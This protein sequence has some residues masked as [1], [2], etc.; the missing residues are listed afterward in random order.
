MSRKRRQR[1]AKTKPTQD[2][3]SRINKVISSDE[4]PKEEKA[5]PEKKQYLYTEILSHEC[6][7]YLTGPMTELFQL[8]GND[9]AYEAMKKCQETGR[10]HP[11][12]EQ[13]TTNTNANS[14][15]RVYV[16]FEGE[17]KESNVVGYLWV[18]VDMDLYGLPQLTVKQWYISPKVLNTLMAGRLL[19]RFLSYILG[20]GSRSKVQRFRGG[21]MQRDT[22]DFW[23]KIKGFKGKEVM[24]EFEGSASD[25]IAQNPILRG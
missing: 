12:I 6:R 7:W 22:V 10:M 8:T 13:M 5:L 20:L 2:K 25:L 4:G 16:C 23:S 19:K 24:M 17:M 3:V 21:V 11:L 9:K 14:Y 18:L 15:E 1:R